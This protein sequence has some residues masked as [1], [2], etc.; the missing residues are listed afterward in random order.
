MNKGKKIE[1]VD[2]LA[3]RLAASPNF[4]LTDFTGIAVKPMTQLRR[5]LREAGGEYVVVKNTLALR[6][7]SST[8]VEGL[9]D[10]F[11]GPTGVVFAGADPLVAAKVLAEF[12]KD[13][14]TL[15]IKAG[16]IDGRAMTAA[17]VSR[18]ASLPPKDQLM[19]QLAGTF[20]APLQGFVGALSGLL[21]Q[22]VGALEA[23]RRQRANG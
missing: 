15:L 10:L 6:A 16:L 23:L 5:Q 20:Q 19:G 1:A 18:L 14:E 2:T 17:Q 22:M 9:D 7:F 13:H 11:K 8:A 3:T 21:T 12:Q 4:Y